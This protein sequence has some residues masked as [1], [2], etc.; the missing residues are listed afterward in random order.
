MKSAPPSPAAPSRDRAR[1]LAH[2][3]TVTLDKV[4]GLRQALPRLHDLENALRERGLV[5]LNDAPLPTT[6]QIRAQIA[7]LSPH[8]SPD[9]QAARAHLLSSL[10]R[11]RKPRRQDQPTIAN[12]DDLYV[13]EATISQFLEELQHEAPSR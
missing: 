13:G 6:D 8:D 9:M 5:A 11:R 7:R 10:D 12:T 1:T 4:P 3:L 2:I